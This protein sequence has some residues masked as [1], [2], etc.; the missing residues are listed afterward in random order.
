MQNKN[1]V[2]DLDAT[3]YYAGDTIEK[4]CDAK[5]V[6]YFVKKMNLSF[7]QAEKLIADIRSRYAYDV[8]ALESELPFSKAEF[9]DYVCDIDVS[10]LAADKELDAVLRL[11]PQPKYILTDSISKHVSDTLRAIH[12][13]IDN[14]KGV[15]DARDMA[16]TFKYNPQS[17]R[18][19]LQKY[20]LN[21]KDCIMFEDS[22]TN[23]KTA[24]S[25]G[26]S[27]VLIRPEAK[28]AEYIDYCF[29]DIKTALWAL[30]F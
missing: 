13:G 17:Y 14:F 9:M 1:L 16:Y 20:N 11:L 19:F 6:E 27:T 7:S 5:V 12:V 30:F 18:L 10:S 8:E 4:L 25:L 15:F 26:F 2:F 3:L 28:G 23:L 22:L 21:A 29:S 24:K